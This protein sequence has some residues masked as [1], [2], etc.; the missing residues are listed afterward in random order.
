MTNTLDDYR[1]YRFR[2]GDYISAVKDGIEVKGAAMED[3]GFSGYAQYHIEI[4]P[5]TTVAL[6]HN[7]SPATLL[8]KARVARGEV[9]D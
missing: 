3:L 7:T 1:H 5:G 8:F 4:F 9:R 2:K 6:N